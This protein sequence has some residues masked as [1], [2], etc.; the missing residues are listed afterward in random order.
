[1]HP[2]VQSMGYGTRAVQLL[3]KYYEG[4]F[5]CVAETDEATFELHNWKVSG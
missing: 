1:M 3:R 5:P 2:D 4:E